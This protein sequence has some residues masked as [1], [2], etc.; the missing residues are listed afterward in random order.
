MKTLTA[1]FILSLALN[2]SAHSI[3]SSLEKI[4]GEYKIDIG[5]SEPT[6]RADETVR[7]NFE[8]YSSEDDSAV[9]YSEVWILIRSGTQTLLSGNLNRPKNGLLPS[10]SYVFPKEGNYEFT[11]RYVRD[12]TKLVET[13]FDLAVEKGEQQKQTKLPIAYG[14]VGLLLG[15]MLALILR[16]KS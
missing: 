6:I 10:L 9:D 11:V 4:E 15:F 12:N 3:G 16:R 14:L 5:V 7:F 8:L 2:A 13:T 1:I